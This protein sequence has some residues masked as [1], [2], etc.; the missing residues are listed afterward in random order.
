[1]HYLLVLLLI[2][3]YSPAFSSVYSLDKLLE[4]GEKN[5]ENIK[6]VEYFADSQLY[7]AKQQKY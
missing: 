7:L 1:M 3:I 2:F 4:I 6:A 5:S